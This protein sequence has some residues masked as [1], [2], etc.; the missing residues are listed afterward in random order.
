MNSSSLFTRSENP[1]ILKILC[2]SML[3]IYTLPIL[4]E[5]TTKNPANRVSKSI[6][7]G[8]QIGGVA[9][10]SGAI[11]DRV[12]PFILP[13]SWYIQRKWR[14]RVVEREVKEL[15]EHNIS[16]SQDITYDTAWATSWLSYMVVLS[17]LAK[18]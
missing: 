17:L 11:F 18:R 2:A 5:D 10:V 13:I 16:C 14:N 8:L 6:I 15:N 9:G 3:I 7:T 4:S 1:R 12:F